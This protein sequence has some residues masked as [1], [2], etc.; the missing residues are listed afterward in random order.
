MAVIR[1]YSNGNCRVTLQADGTKVRSWSG[2]PSPE[3]PES[4]D[5]KVTDRCDAGCGFCHESSTRRGL[6]AAMPDVLRLID[7]LPSGPEI[8]IG[9]GDPLSHP[10]IERMMEVMVE[11]GLVPNLTINGLHARRYKDRIDLIRKAGL[12]FG[13]GISHAPNCRADIM[14]LADANAV[15]H[16]IAGVAHPMELADYPSD[17]KVLV[18]GYKRYG[19]GTE[20]ER[21]N[22]VESRLAAWKYWIGTIMRRF[23][24]V[25]FDNLALQQ[26]NIKS[27]I[28][29]EA[30][31]ARYMGD[32]GLYTMY[33]DA[34]E[35]TFAK[36]STSPRMPAG[37]MT[38]KEMFSK[39]RHGA[40][41]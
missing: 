16:V 41:A 28:T 1:E 11:R 36:S 9:G 12:I 18:L 13:L 26:L 25:S 38:T 23:K 21:N 20:F 7:G 15:L 10:D 29:K 14:A 35:C 33:I 17:V 32:D 31:D 2:D 6:P 40:L 19:L 30:W 4:I 8:A 22:D 5:L 3:F 37:R 24:S 34:V 27:L 39:V